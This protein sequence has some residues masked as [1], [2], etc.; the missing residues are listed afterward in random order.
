MAQA[1]VFNGSNQYVKGT[2]PNSSPYTSISAFTFEARI[3]GARTSFGTTQRL[4]YADNVFRLFI[5]ASSTN[6]TFASNA[7]G[8]T[9]SLSV[10]IGSL[11]TVGDFLVRCVYDPANGSSNKWSIEVWNLDGTGRIGSVG[12]SGVSA[13]MNAGNQLFTIGAQTN[14]TNPIQAKVDWARWWNAATAYNGSAPSAS[15]PGGVTYFGDWEFEGNANDSSAQAFHLT[16]FNT[17]TYETTPGG[18]I[19]LQATV[20]GTSTGALVLRLTKSLSAQPGATS[21]G[22]ALLGVG[23]N[24]TAQAAG[25]ST[26][27]A[28]ARIGKALVGLAAGSSTGLA[29]ARISKLLA[30]VSGGN[31]SGQLTLRITKALN[32][33]AGGVSS[34]ALTLHAA[35]PAVQ[36]APLRAGGALIVTS[37]EQP[38]KSG[39]AL[40]VTNKQGQASKA[41]GALIEGK[42][43]LKIKAGGVTFP[44][45][46]LTLK[47]GGV[48]VLRLITED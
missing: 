33:I 17:P 43:T 5:N 18:A 9:A 31:A 3:R 36:P 2:C 44:P 47:A 14:A 27:S 15:A 42:Y 8:D 25:S 38:L 20:A 4:V 7:S 11:A 1:I 48:I 34:A 16:E 13:S 28:Q 22:S 46:E 39:G 35:L 21:G 40:I 26:A 23:K 37:R 19:S 32:A 6:L 10:N 12:S 45:R 30:S 24:L 29:E 41:G